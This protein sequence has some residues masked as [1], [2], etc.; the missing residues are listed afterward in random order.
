MTAGRVDERDRRE[1]LGDVER[2][3][4]I[5]AAFVMLADDAMKSV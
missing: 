4:G 3:I 5:D 1:V 2:K